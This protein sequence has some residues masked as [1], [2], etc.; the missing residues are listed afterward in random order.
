MSDPATGE[1]CAGDSNVQ[2]AEQLRLTHAEAADDLADTLSR[3]G[4]RRCVDA[5]PAGRG[6]GWRGVLTFTADDDGHTA[7]RMTVVDVVIP[8]AYPFRPPTVHPGDRLWAQAAVSRTF[9]EEY[10]EPSCGW[11]RD[12]D[13]A[14]CL[15]DEADATLL[16]W[17]DGTAVLQQATAWLAAD[18]AD[19]VNDAPALD[20]ERYL[21]SAAEHR[22]LLY[23][24]LDD[25]DGIVLRCRAHRNDV[26]Q[27]SGRAI[28][29]KSGSRP[30][31]RRWEPKPSSC[32][33]QASLTARSETGL[34]CLR[35]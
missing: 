3:A 26:Q 33:P 24:P 11:H 21:P 7:V 30:G 1:P 31:T 18:A 17:A 5:L 8:D 13:L 20:L 9:G 29:R 16:P 32:R 2:A 22:V 28:M 35:R 15:F 4:F 27:L 12:G 19:W 14:L 34:V 25:L 23:G 10:Y 6:S